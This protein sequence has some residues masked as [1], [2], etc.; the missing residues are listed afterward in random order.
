MQRFLVANIY[1]AAKRNIYTKHERL[2]EPQTSELIFYI[3]CKHT[4]RKIKYRQTQSI[5]ITISFNS[6]VFVS[7]FKPN[8]TFVRSLRLYVF[9]FRLW[10]GGRPNCTCTRQPNNTRRV[11]SEYWI[12]PDCLWLV[13]RQTERKE[14]T[15]NKM[16]VW[17]LQHSV[18]T[19]K[20][21]QKSPKHTYT[22]TQMAPL[23][24]AQN[25]LTSRSRFPLHNNITL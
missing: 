15:R 23:A 20:R 16:F 3:Y 11:L 21:V 12:L 14:T 22:H 7:H 6:F 2:N 10:V 1:F 13:D 9:F 4:R 17:R 5:F 25:R 18:H 19:E 8:F 24:K